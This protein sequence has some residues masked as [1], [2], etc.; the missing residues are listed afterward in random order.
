MEGFLFI[1]QIIEYEYPTQVKM[2]QSFVPEQELCTIGFIIYI[3]ILLCK[4][5]EET[6]NEKRSISENVFI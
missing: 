4:D 5:F 6:G 3:N 2:S 1:L